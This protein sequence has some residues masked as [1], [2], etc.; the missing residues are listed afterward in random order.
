MRDKNDNEELTENE[1][2]VG[3]FR[4]LHYSLL[5]DMYDYTATAQRGDQ[6][7]DMRSFLATETCFVRVNYSPRTCAVIPYW[8]LVGLQD[9]EYLM[10]LV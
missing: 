7:E 9:L 6:H 1:E 4:I 8:M 3:L 10:F 5:G 2:Y